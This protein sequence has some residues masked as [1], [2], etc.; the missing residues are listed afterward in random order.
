MPSEVALMAATLAWESL[1][2]TDPNGQKTASIQRAMVPGGWL[3]R[4]VV[5]K[6]SLVFV[7]DQ[8]HAW[9]APPT[10]TREIEFEG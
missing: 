9:G 6:G 1:Q 10:R 2:E 4:D 3:V 8:S 5:A 7:P